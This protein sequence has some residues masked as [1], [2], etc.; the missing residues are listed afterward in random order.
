MRAGVTSQDAHQVGRVRPDRVVRGY[1][2]NRAARKCLSWRWGGGGRDQNAAPR[3][4]LNI[5]HAHVGH[6]V[7]V[8]LF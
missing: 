3:R 5:K 8:A 6:S 7:V 4:S 2:T 1:K